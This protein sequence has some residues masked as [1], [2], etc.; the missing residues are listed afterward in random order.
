MITVQSNRV[1]KLYR[2]IT[3]YYRLILFSLFLSVPALA[4]GAESKS[5][6]LDCAALKMSRAPNQRVQ[7]GS[8]PFSI[9][10][11]QGENWCSYAL[12][13]GAS[14]LKAPGTVEVPATSLS[15]DE[16]LQ[17]ILGT[18]R[19]FTMA[20]TISNFGTD[21][22]APGQLKVVVDELI[23]K[24]FFSQILGGV[25]SAER[26]FQLLDSQSALDTS[27]GVTCVRFGARVES[28]TVL[29]A[30]PVILILKF[31]DNKV[32]IHPQS[33][34][35]KS[36]LV[37]I[38]FATLEEEKTPPSENNIIKEVEPFLRSLEFVITG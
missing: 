18:V 38:G 31:L 33:I 27:L 9:L 10:P 5:V 22:T 23:S 15:N 12:P 11:P 3:T 35:R 19:F 30:T 17:I 36:T 24:H 7:L 21:P 32:C 26:R 14:F 4:I 2:H 13:G 25:I 28:R 8:P 6:R 16:V 37:W 20:M 1:S 29:S 34:G